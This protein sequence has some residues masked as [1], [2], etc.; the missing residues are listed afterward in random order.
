MLNPRRFPI[1]ANTAYQHPAARKGE[2]NLP[3]VRAAGAEG[4]GS[5]MQDPVLGC[6]LSALCS[7]LLSSPKQFD[8]LATITMYQAI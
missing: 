2:R 6:A 1:N 8:V 7:A 3:A 4:K 5:S